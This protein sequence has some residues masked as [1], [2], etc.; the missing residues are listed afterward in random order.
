MKLLLLSLVISASGEPL[1]ET[2]PPL[3]DENIVVTGAIPRDPRESTSPVSVLTGAELD[4]ELRPQIGKA[5][6]RQ[7]F[8][9]FAQAR[10]TWLRSC[11]E[12]AK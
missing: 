4:R 10:R 9:V 12:V 6:A 5:L 8:S 3:A 11:S 2:D 1:S 7:P